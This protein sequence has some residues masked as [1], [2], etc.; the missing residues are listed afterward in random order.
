MLYLQVVQG[1]KFNIFYPDLIDKT[2]TPT[3]KI[4]RDEGYPDTVV[5]VFK[6]SA[7]YE[8]IAFRIVNKEWEHSHR[9]GFRSVCAFFFLFILIVRVSFFN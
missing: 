4:V 9:N 6:A 5:L 3:Y 8:D 2:K 1:Y 7:P